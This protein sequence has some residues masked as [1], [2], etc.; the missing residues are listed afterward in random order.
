M[1][2]PEV[3]ATKREVLMTSTAIGYH[4]WNKTEETMPREQRRAWQWEQIKVLL[5][6]VSH[7]EFYRQ[8]FAAAGVDPAKIRTWEDFSTRVPYLTKKDLLEDQKAHPPYGQRLMVPEQEISQAWIT[9]GTSGVG[10]EVH[11][12]SEEDVRRGA[13]HCFYALAW[14]GMQPGDLSLICWPVATMA[15]GLVLYEALRWFR[16]HT[17]LVQIFDSKTKIER[18]KTFQPHYIWVTPVYLTRLSTLCEEV[19]FLPR[20]DLHR[21]K[22]VFISTGSYPV[23]WAERMQ[24][25]W[26]APLYDVYGTTQIGTMFGATCEEGVVREGK[27]GCFHFI[28]QW[29]L[30][31]IVNPET[32]EPTAYGEEGDVVATTFNRVATPL[33]RF[34]HGDRVRLLPPDYCRCGRTGLCLEAGTIARYDDMI[35]IKGVNVWPDATDAVLFSYPEVDEYNARV[36]VDQSAGREEIDMKV[37]FKVGTEA[38]RRREILGR[39]PGQLRERTGVGME[40]REVAPQEVERFEYKAMRWTDERITGLQKVK[41]KEK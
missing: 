14:A 21:L 41:F 30:L 8:R 9:S 24:E 15:G 33:V 28:D 18:M 1:P 22:G 36:Y 20:R 26:G 5:D 32:G 6:R 4:Y 35:K 7:N 40:V 13:E 37:A 12:L 39:L 17:M 23:E 25:F 38:A 11:A 19:N 31:E 34:R 2:D 10:Q 29:A 27:R 3:T 16:A